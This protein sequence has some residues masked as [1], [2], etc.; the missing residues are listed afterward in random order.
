MI[1]T[2][3]DPYEI[4]LMG[5]SAGAISVGFHMLSPLSRRLFKRAILQSGSAL[6][7]SM[8]IGHENGPIY[9]EKVADALDC[10]YLSRRNNKYAT[11]NSETFDCIR[12]ASTMK[13][14]E[15]QTKI[16]LSR[17][18]TGFHPTVDGDF[19]PEHPYHLTHSSAYGP[20]HEILLGTTANEGAIFMTLGLP[21][22]FPANAEL[23][24]NLTQ[25][26]IMDKLSQKAPE[27]FQE[28]SRTYLKYVFDFMFG[29]LPS[30]N[31]S[32]IAARMDHIL[33][34]SLFLC[35]N[36]I[37]VDTF[38]KIKG[39]QAFYYQFNPRP[40]R[41]KHYSWVK[42]ALHAEEIQFVFGRPLTDPT[43]YTKQ[44]IELSREIMA[45][46]SHFARYGTPVH[47]RKWPP[48]KSDSRH[49][50]VYDLGK[51]AVKTGLPDNRCD[52]YFDQFY[53]QMMNDYGYFV[54]PDLRKRKRSVVTEIRS[55]DDKGH[56]NVLGS[57]PLTWIN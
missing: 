13:L 51:L 34:N 6:T 21:D 22:I 4:T 56:I 57:S 17:R 19:F 54:L 46:W 15:L 12:N 23:P 8:M 2:S 53:E 29:G 55:R 26:M 38:T 7:P 43:Q 9:L 24:K 16:A 31:G 52:Q 41:A 37:L 47:S 20:Q 36:T 25:N 27:G 44:E 11:F 35:P 28:N 50:L 40:S 14:L 1:G 49:H 18:S 42:G 10:P 32:M 33:G 5:E 3:G 48:C 30:G 45:D 39:R